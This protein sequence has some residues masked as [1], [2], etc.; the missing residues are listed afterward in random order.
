VVGEP[1]G[2]MREAADRLYR[3]TIGIEA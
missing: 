2:D 1:P 3:R